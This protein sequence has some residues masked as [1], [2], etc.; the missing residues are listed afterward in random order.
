V[1]SILNKKEGAHSPSFP[2][3]KKNVQLKLSLLSSV[4]FRMMLGGFLRV[5]FRLG[6]MTMRSV[7]V[8]PGL[9]VIARFMLLSRFLM[10]RGGML[11]M[12][13]RLL[14]VLGALVF[15]HCDPPLLPN[16]AF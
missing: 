11:V 3:K 5:M 14:V 15:W 1:V 12:F 4:L 13:R 16:D 10:V 7:R 9:F 2:E 6:M 8:M